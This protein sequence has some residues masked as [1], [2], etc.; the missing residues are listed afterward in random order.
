MSPFPLVVAHAGEGVV[1]TTLG[2]QI[3]RVTAAQTGGAVGI[4]DDVVP[5]HGGPPLHVHT[6]EDEIFHV[7]AGQ[8]RFWCGDE[9]F[10]AGPGTV[11][12]L[13]RGT[14]HRFQNI[15]QSEGRLVITVTPGGF[16]GFFVDIQ[17]EST[18]EAINAS[19]ARYGLVFLAQPGASSMPEQAA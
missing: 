3:V 1:S 18:P 11:V 4:F 16:E 19:A 2:R 10:D 6:C 5:P 13:P 15:G 9:S 17:R 8:F 12:A 7:A 14:P